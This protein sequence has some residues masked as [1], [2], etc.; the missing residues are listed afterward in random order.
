MYMETAEMPDD[1]EERVRFLIFEVLIAED[2]E[3]A[4][5]S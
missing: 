4:F 5:G 1:V 2:Q 3:T